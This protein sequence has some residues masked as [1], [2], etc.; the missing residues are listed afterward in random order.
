M[1]KSNKIGGSLKGSG[2]GQIPT[3]SEKSSPSKG[4]SISGSALGKGGGITSA[5]P[6]TATSDSR[7]TSGDNKK[8]AT[9][10]SGT[11]SKGAGGSG[12]VKNVH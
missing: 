9:R 4:G 11:G 7:P 5:N 10:P 8:G 12:R 3:S 2:I 1:P 6:L